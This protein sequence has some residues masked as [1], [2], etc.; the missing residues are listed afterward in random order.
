MAQTYFSLT[1]LHMLAYQFTGE[2]LLNHNQ[3]PEWVAHF[4]NRILLELEMFC[5]EM[6]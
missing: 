2:E 6:K 5:D 4:N 3:L 1:L